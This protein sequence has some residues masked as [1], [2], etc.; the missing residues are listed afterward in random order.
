V[1]GHKIVRNL[2]IE[3]DGQPYPEQS[4]DLEWDNNNDCL[5]YNAFQKKKK[6]KIGF[7]TDSIPYTDKKIF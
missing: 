5:T 4:W 6:K 1:F 2:S 7:K 3:I